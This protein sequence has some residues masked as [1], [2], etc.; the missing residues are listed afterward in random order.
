MQVTIRISTATYEKLLRNIPQESTAYAIL[1][2]IVSAEVKNRLNAGPSETFN[3]VVL[4][5]THEE[6]LPMLG[7]AKQHCPTAVQEIEGA[8]WP[9]RKTH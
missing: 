5:C 9:S 8:L 4:R 1:R 3:G 7:A 6:V 2:R